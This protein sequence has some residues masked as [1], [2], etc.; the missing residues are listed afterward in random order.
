LLKRAKDDGIPDH[1]SASTQSRARKALCARETAF[2]PIVQDIVVPTRTGDQIIAIQ[3]PLAMLDAATRDCEPLSRIVYE[4]VQ[5]HGE[6]TQ[7]APWTL[8]WYHDEIGMN[9]LA[10][11]DARKTVGF[12]WSLA[13]FGPRLLCTDNCWFVASATRSNIVKSIAGGSSH[14]RK[15]LLKLLYVN[16]VGNIVDGLLLHLQGPKSTPP[17][18]ASLGI[19]CGDLDALFKFLCSKGQNAN[20]P[21]PLHS[22]VVSL[23]SGWARDGSVL[24]AFN[25]L[26]MS[27][28]VPH[29]DA[30]IREVV[31]AL[32]RA[33]AERDA[34]R[35]TGAAFDALST[36]LGWSHSSDNILMDEAIKFD[37][38]SALHVDWFHTYLQTG[39]F[40]VL[41]HV[42]SSRG[43]CCKERHI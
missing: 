19:V 33:A 42:F 22:N 28:M 29:T 43:G 41:A 37:V 14:L 10:P 31:R 3:H 15:L 38:A 11:D 36:E 27:E 40:C 26:D 1:I 2:G 21:C 35:M 32:A 24:R 7:T 5:R 6:P 8:V 17:I 34:G 4:A 13:E 12:Y 39:I 20:V 16:P 9:P 30:T 25:C 18:F 23:K